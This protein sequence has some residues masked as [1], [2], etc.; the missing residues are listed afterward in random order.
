MEKHISIAIVE[1]NEEI[2]KSLVAFIEKAEGILC[3]GQYANAEIA[4]KEIP[5][6]LPDIVLMDIGLPKM[7]GIECVRKLKPY[8]RVFNL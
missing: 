3:I 6:I 2:R 1:D 5:D 7:N 4:I 8:V